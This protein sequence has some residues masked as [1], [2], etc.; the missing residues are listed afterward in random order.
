MQLIGLT[1]G[2]ASGK[3]TIASRLAEL[4]AAVVDADR[5][6]REVVEPGTPALAE[7]RRAFGDGVIAP[8]GTLDRPELGAIVF[9]DPAALRILNGITHPAVLRESTARFEAAAVADPDAIVVY[10]V[11]LLVESANRYPFDLVVVAH[12]DAATRAR[13]LFELRGMDPVA[14]ERRI[15]SQ[16]SDAERL[17]AAD[18]VI[19]TGG[20][21]EE[22]YRQV[23]ALWAGLRG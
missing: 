11:P 1:G 3:S 22:T 5:I 12:A 16:V 9:G 6:A 19:D 23:D 17:S 10:D 20:T 7:I 4:G 8:D 2:I 13:R 15:G 21:L 18:L 14:A